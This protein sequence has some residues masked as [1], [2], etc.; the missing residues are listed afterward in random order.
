MADDNFREPEY[1]G[2]GVYIGHDGYQFWLRLQS[3]ENTEGQIAL[4][5]GTL[6]N[7]KMYTDR[8]TKKADAS[9][10]NPG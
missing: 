5:R 4:D 6:D 3:H 10:A 2:D 1:L 7:M 9:R 8:I